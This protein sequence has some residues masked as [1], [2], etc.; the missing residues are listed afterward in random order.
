MATDTTDRVW[1]D[2]DVRGKPPARYRLSMQGWMDAWEGRD[3]TSTHP[4][5]LLGFKEGEKAL[6]LRQRLR[7]GVDEHADL[8]NMGRGLE[9][10]GWREVPQHRHLRA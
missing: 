4:R 6:A 2:S 1:W 7:S 3:P 9:M 5:Y 8:I 10:L